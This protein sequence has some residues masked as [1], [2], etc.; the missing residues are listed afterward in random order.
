[1]TEAS[2]RGA[3]KGAP[4]VFRGFRGEGKVAVQIQNGLAVTDLL[5]CAD[6]RLRLEVQDIE[7]RHY[8]L[9]M[10]VGSEGRAPIWAKIPIILHRDLPSDARVKWAYL[11][12]RRR[13]T[14]W[15]WQAQFV[16][17]RDEWP[18]DAGSS[19]AC[20]VDLGWRLVP[21]GLRVAFWAGDDGRSGEL[22]IPHADLARWRKADDL[23]SIRDK[24]FNVAR[25]ALATWL[26]GGV[27]VPDWLRVELSHLHQWHSAAR[28]AALLWRWNGARYERG[29]EVAWQP[30]PGF[31]GVPGS[32]RFAGDEEIFPRLWAE[33]GPPPVRLVRQQ[34]PESGPLAGRPVPPFRPRADRPLPHRGLRGCRLA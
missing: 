5:A 29:R 2:L 20:G 31:E 10:R 28:L 34:P 32:G 6:T 22:V 26:R 15:R 9:W 24:N 14:H 27:T 21:G 25:D 23:A 33:A 7:R 19:G 3:R 18:S 17:E 16:L 8:L 4:P 1:M 11:L 30:P 13:G 12:R